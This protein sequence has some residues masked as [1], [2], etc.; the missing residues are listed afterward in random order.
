MSD[1]VPVPLDFDEGVAPMSDSS[2]TEA[3]VSPRTKKRSI[4]EDRVVRI[5]GFASLGLVLLFLVTIVSALFLGIDGGKTQFRTAAERDVAV[6][7]ARFDEDPTEKT[8]LDY[9]AALVAVG[10]Y[11]TAQEVIDRSIESV[12]QSASGSITA[13]QAN[14]LFIQKD[15]E[16]ALKAA[17]ESR[18]IAQAS[19]DAQVKAGGPMGSI[20][21]LPSTYWTTI[22]LQARCCVETEEWE[23][24]LGFYD[25]YLAEKNTDANALVARGNVKAELG[26]TAGAR[27]DFEGALAFVP[28]FEDAQDGLKKIGAE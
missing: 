6:A 21:A 20:A 22:L 17:D 1:Q 9:V 18:K 2:S 23:R 24:A 10:R 28:D 11:G 26:D 13:A 12:D 16:G 27:T 15:Y 5:M 25:E 4:F 8:V 3:V 7:A 19:Y 14:L